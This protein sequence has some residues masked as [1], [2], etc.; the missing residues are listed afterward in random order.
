MI[1]NNDD[2]KD[3]DF[4]EV[5]ETSDDESQEAESSASDR[6]PDIGGDTM[7]DVSGQLKVEKLVAKIDAGDP[8]EAAHQ[9]EVRKRLEE[10][11]EKQDKD[12]DS[13]FN[14]N[15]DDDL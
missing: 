2:K 4:N 11:Q 9:R 13:T 7:V 1:G 5:D 8:D 12:L 15:L 10:I 14:F 3:T 6:I